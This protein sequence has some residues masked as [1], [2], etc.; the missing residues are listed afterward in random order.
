MAS[1]ADLGITVQVEYVNGRRSD[2]EYLWA[3]W[4]L[5][6]L[7]HPEAFDVVHAHYGL[8]GFVAGFQR[9]PLVVSFCG[10]DLLGTPD[11]A[12]RITRKSR[13]VVRLS[14]IAACRADSIIC[15]SEQL[16]AALP[17]EY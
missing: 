11:G 12:G 16:R 10:D 7:A 2:W 15:K 1:I 4:R 3:I 6:R 13:L 17:R 5:R 9:L 14:R 8:T